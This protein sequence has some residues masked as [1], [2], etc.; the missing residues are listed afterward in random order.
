MSEFTP[1]NLDKVL[2][3]VSD[4]VVVLDRD[5]RFT[6]LNRSAER[7]LRGSREELI[8]SV[9][10]GILEEGIGIDAEM[11][12]RAA[13]AAREP[14]EY[15]VLVP[16]TRRWLTVRVFPCDTDVVLYLRDVTQRKVVE[17]VLSR[18]QKRDAARLQI[19]AD[20]GAVLGSSL[21]IVDTLGVLTRLI[22]PGL[23]DSC[24]VD[25]LEGSELHRVAAAHRDAAGAE[26]NLALGSPGPLR[27]RPV[28]IYR[29]ARTGEAELVSVVDDGWLRAA[30]REEVYLKLVRS[31]SPP[32]SMIIVPIRGRA[33]VL[34]VLTLCMLGGST[35]Y[36]P[37]DLSTAQAIADRA[38]MAIENARLFEQTVQAKRL[39]ED[40]LGIVSHDLR[41]PLHAIALN[42]QAL[43]R[44]T[45][46]KEVRAI[47]RAVPRAEALISDL[48]TAAAL[49]AGSLPIEKHPEDVA[50]VVEEA[51]DMQ[52]PKAS[53]RS[54]R[55]EMAV[56]GDVRTVAMDRHRVLEV[57]GNLLDNALRVT[58]AGGRVRVDVHVCE[59]GVAVDVSDTGPGIPPEQQAHLFDRFWQ[60]AT[61]HRAGAGLG[62]AIAKGI[63]EA[64][65]GSLRVETTPG[66]GATFSFQ[67]PLDA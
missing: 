35:S 50:A 33:G 34:G 46:A 9:A 21:Q 27:E 65:H 11:R 23:A 7:Y 42:A 20:A 6:H 55:L 62:L 40:V 26:F 14:V 49:D 54:V 24:I 57:L 25:L 38:A 30:S 22:V 43:S 39:R 53:Q 5:W 28:G 16:T 8:G 58:P 3:C 45:D 66:H 19:I 56:A 15:D 13:V 63:V 10:W 47:E 2:D 17:D 52:R 59:G 64:H 31:A 18:E 1:A 4:A 61:M 36:E 37:L 67:L 48:L 41:T 60:G 44:K 29:V 32:T 12:V 51:V